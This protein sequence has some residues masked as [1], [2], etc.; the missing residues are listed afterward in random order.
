MTMDV[1]IHNSR[2]FVIQ[3]SSKLFRHACL[4]ECTCMTDSVSVCS[5]LTSGKK[6]QFFFLPLGFI[7]TKSVVIFNK[8]ICIIFF[9]PEFLSQSN[10]MGLLH[11]SFGY[12]YVKGILGVKC[13]NTGDD[14][15]I[16]AKPYI[17]S[18][19]G[20]VYLS[21]QSS[22]LRHVGISTGTT[23]TN[24]SMHVTEDWSHCLVTTD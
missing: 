19:T 6:F 14:H 7:K 17:S 12:M 11:F 8:L 13:Y 1:H 21:I 5:Y 2:I 16:L 20:L 4:Y 18:G 10:K 22:R 3:P 15:V 23:C 9:P 24:A